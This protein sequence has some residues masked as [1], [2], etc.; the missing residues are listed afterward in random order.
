MQTIESNSGMDRRTPPALHTIDIMPLPAAEDVT[1]AGGQTI[2]VQRRE[3]DQLAKVTLLVPGGRFELGKVE[4]VAGLNLLK[5]GTR[6]HSG[7]QLAEMLDYNGAEFSCGATDHYG[8]ISLRGLRRNLDRVLPLMFEMLAEPAYPLAAVDAC[9]RSMATQLQVQLTT[10]AFNATLN[11]QRQMAG[12]EHVLSQPP[13]MEQIMALSGEI[14]DRSRHRWLNPQL[15]GIYACGAVDDAL[16]AMVE[17]G[18]QSLPVLTNDNPVSFEPM[19]PCEPCTDYIEVPGSLQQSL[20][21]WLPAIDISNPDYWALRVAVHALGG[22]FGARLMQNIR[23]DKGYTYGISAQ[24]GWRPELMTVQ[25]GCECDAR[26]LD[27]VIEELRSELAGMATR[28][29]SDGEFRRVN[30]NLRSWLASM[31]DTAESAQGR[32]VALAGNCMPADYYGQFRERLPE[33]TIDDIA[34]VSAR[35]LRPELLRFS[36]AGVRS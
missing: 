5:E 33:I 9:R 4:A 20:Q 1:L 13:G 15:F 17:S 23:E 26:Y 12:P 7:E 16:L 32:R 2:N 3:G 25:I 19:H 18:M 24:L 29:L 30:L 11:M 8:L 10:P 6:S 14:L 31:G 21:V 27:G 36:I 35:Y 28:P 22:Y 34:A